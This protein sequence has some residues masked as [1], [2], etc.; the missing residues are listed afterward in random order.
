MI[1]VWIAVSI[2]V[3]ALLATGV[4][5]LAQALIASAVLLR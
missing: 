4:V 5:R 3:L 2:V 1:V